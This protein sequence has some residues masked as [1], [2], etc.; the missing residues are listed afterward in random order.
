MVR[1][2]WIQI[3]MHSVNSFKAT[4]NTEYYPS[5]SNFTWLRTKSDNQKSTVDLVPKIQWWISLGSVHI[6]KKL[7][8]RVYLTVLIPNQAYPKLGTRYSDHWW[9]PLDTKIDPQFQ[10]PFLH[11][12]VEALFH[13]LISTL[14]YYVTLLVVTRISF[15]PD[16]SHRFSWN[17]T[18]YSSF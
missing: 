11:R 12:L 13:N 9:T 4:L 14:L 10:S 15:V 7:S 3:T 17:F 8:T 6:I 5:N 1:N 16:R 18:S 2:T